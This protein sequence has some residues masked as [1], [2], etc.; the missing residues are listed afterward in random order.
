MNTN[1]I[2]HLMEEVLTELIL[3]EFVEVVVPIGFIGSFAMAYHGPN[4]IRWYGGWKRV[5]NLSVF[6]MP[7]AEMVLLGKFCINGISDIHKFSSLFTQK[8]S[9]QNFCLKDKHMFIKIYKVCI[10]CSFQLNFFGLF[11]PLHT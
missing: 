8:V 2:Q 10:F 7:V 4:K 5:V 1:A 6:L 11:D 9:Y 3:N